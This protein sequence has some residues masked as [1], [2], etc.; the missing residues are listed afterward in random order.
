VRNGT[1][2]VTIAI[3]LFDSGDALVAT[4]RS[5]MVERAEAS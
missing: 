5:A 3:E 2:F 1:G 4:C